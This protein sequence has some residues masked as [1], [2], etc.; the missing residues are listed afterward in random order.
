LKTAF[1]IGYRYWLLTCYF[2]SDLGGIAFVAYFLTS[3]LGLTTQPLPAIWP[4]DPIPR[5][6]T[7]LALSTVFVPM[8]I[9]I[10]SRRTKELDKI[11]PK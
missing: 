7:F 10:V 11:G 4:N 2:V 5:L 1:R 8:L 6:L 9:D 3:F